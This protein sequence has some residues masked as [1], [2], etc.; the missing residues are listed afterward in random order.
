[1]GNI[2]LHS[3]KFLFCEPFFFKALKHFKKKRHVVSKFCSNKKPMLFGTLSKKKLKKAK[4]KKMWKKI[5]EI[6]E[7]EKTRILDFGLECMENSSKKFSSSSYNFFCFK[8]VGHSYIAL[9]TCKI[10]YFSNNLKQLSLKISY[11]IKE[12]KNMKIFFYLPW[13]WIYTR[14]KWGRNS[15]NL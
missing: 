11:N 4:T 7:S 10:F 3:T 2:F 8:A 6:I 14:S 5:F 1:M 12:H 15:I 13:V 9:L